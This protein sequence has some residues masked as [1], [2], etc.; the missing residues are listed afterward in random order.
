MPD[1]NG[2]MGDMMELAK[3]EKM[4]EQF[5]SAAE[6]FKELLDDEALT[7]RDE[8]GL[9]DINGLL[10]TMLGAMSDEG[11]ASELL[12]GMTDITREM[13][14]IMEKHAAK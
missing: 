5:S 12:E 3:D 11:P 9:P 8:N 14:N 7:K 10:A 1:F 13:E 6:G 2:I 4:Q